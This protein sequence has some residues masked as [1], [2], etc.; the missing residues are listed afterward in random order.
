MTTIVEAIARV[1]IPER[2]REL[3]EGDWLVEE[4][5]TFLRD[6][7]NIDV[8]VVPWEW[9]VQH[10]M[11]AYESEL[12]DEAWFSLWLL[13][14]DETEAFLRKEASEAAK[15]ARQQLRDEMDEWNDRYPMR[16]PD[17]RDGC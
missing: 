13:I 1:Y 3:C 5:R 4:A 16:C 14:D 15:V 6:S 17:R 12:T 11:K 2:V 7:D 9:A 10:V 8:D